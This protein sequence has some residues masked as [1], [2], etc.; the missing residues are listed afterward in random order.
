[1]YTY[2]PVGLISVTLYALRALKC[3]EKAA[4]MS[5][6]IAIYQHFLQFFR[7][8]SDMD[9]HFSQR[10]N[11][12]L[13]T[14]HTFFVYKKDFSCSGHLHKKNKESRNPSHDKEFRLS[15]FIRYVFL[16]GICFTTLPNNTHLSETANE[17]DRTGKRHICRLYVPLPPDTA[18]AMPMCPKTLPDT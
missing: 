6:R 3:N 5:L 8:E 1:M 16:G 10:K 12:S 2:R 15:Y 17:Q 14:K 4:K 13:S 9:A 18:P 7:V 11:K